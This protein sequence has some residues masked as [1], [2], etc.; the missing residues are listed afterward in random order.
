MGTVT[1][2]GAISLDAIKA[3]L[4]GPASPALSNYYR[5]GTYTPSSKSTSVLTYEPAGGGTRTTYQPP[6]YWYD[7]GYDYA[8]IYWEGAVIAD[9]WSPGASTTSAT[10]GIY[11]YYRGQYGPV[12]NQWYI[13]RTYMANNTTQLN[14]G[15]PTSGQISISQLYGATNV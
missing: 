6:T 7:P 14:T 13:R 10:V 2:S 4:G 11:T 12:S 1:S 5:G 15:V 8:R 9:V 3:A